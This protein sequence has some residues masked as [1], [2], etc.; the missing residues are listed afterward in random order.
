METVLM[1]MIGVGAVTFLTS[2]FIAL[3]RESRKAQ[4][5]TIQI[6]PEEVPGSHYIQLESW[7]VYDFHAERENIAHATR[8]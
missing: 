8:R 1:A 6:V 4:S 5:H 2:F 3:C 7:I